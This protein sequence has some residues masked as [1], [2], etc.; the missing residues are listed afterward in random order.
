[1]KAQLTVLDSAEY[2]NVCKNTEEHLI[3]IDKEKDIKFAI[4]DC[5]FCV[6]YVGSTLNK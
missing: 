1:M 4:S 6:F 2:E 5:D 3:N